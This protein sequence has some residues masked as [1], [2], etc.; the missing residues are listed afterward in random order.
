[1]LKVV[2]IQNPQ[3]ST[4]TFSVLPLLNSTVT[5]RSTTLDELVERRNAAW[6]MKVVVSGTYNN[7]EM[8]RFQNI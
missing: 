1:M 8:P 3:I 6:P 4:Y 7:Q 2:L 5:A